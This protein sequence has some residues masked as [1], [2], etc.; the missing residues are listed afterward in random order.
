MHV[1]VGTR[2]PRSVKVLFS[3]ASACMIDDSTAVIQLLHLSLLV[4]EDACE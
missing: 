4:L 2:D 3:F 1:T